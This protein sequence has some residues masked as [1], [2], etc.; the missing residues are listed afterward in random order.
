MN[1]L[2]RWNTLSG[3]IEFTFQ[4]WQYQTDCFSST[5]AVGNDVLQQRHEH[6][7]GH[8]CGCGASWVFW[9]LV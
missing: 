1:L 6:G 8:L 2:I 4:V 9:S 3:A 7:A 5:S